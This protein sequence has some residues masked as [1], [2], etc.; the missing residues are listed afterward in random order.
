MALSP[1]RVIG[2]GHEAV[3]RRYLKACEACRRRRL[4]LLGDVRSG[5]HVG[6]VID[7]PNV[8]QRP[9]RLPEPSDRSA[10]GV[11]V[12]RV[13][14]PCGGPVSWTVIGNDHRPVEPV[15][16]YLAW[17]SRV[18]RSPNT[19]RAYASDLKTYNGN[20]TRCCWPRTVGSATRTRG[21]ATNSRSSMG[22]AAKRSHA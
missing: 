11:R 20:A 12:Q 4:V 7:V 21:Y 17:L 8:A 18:E 2:F 6:A 10:F 5:S 3:D 14:S 1:D 9:R 15:E 13:V 19:V 16:R 22:N